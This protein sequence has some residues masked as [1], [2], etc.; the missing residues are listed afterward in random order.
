MGICYPSAQEMAFLYGVG[1]AREIKVCTEVALFKGSISVSA[2][3]S[4][5]GGFS[6]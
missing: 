4:N 1:S 5:A 3:C 2:S 6:V